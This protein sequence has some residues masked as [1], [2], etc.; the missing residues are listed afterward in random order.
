MSKKQNMRYFYLSLVLILFTFFIF[1]FYDTTKQAMPKKFTKSKSANYHIEYIVYF[2]DTDTTIQA[3]PIYFP[4]LIYLPEIGDTLLYSI[5]SGSR[6]A[7]L[8]EDVD[9]YQFSNSSILY[10]L[11]YIPSN[12]TPC[13]LKYTLWVIN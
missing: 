3:K 1:Y 8:N 6:S 10:R 2:Y 11:C 4:Y 12:H 5:S 13:I 9:I 7:H